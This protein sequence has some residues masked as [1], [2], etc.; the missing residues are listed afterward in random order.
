MKAIRGFVNSRPS[1]TPDPQPSTSAV[2]PTLHK[3]D[4]PT[5]Q[6]HESPI[7]T[8][9]LSASSF[10]DTV[11]TDEFSDSPLYLIETH[12]D[13]TNIYRCEAETTA[14]VA[15]V[16]WPSRSKMISANAVALSGISIQIR[17]G[18][19]RPAEEFLKFGSLFTYVSS[20]PLNSLCLSLS[21]SLSPFQSVT[22]TYIS[23]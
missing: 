10:L 21:L 15:K 1:T 17:D 18:K 3:L 12:Q 6:S 13:R 22:E 2:F 11:V 19:W 16:Q 8:L 7:L 4:L 23:F 20:L 14:S 9:N 5:G